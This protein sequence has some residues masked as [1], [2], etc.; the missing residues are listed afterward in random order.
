MAS[1][2]VVRVEASDKMLEGFSAG[3]GGKAWS[4]AT[5]E[6][7]QPHTSPTP[8]PLR[9]PSLGS[10]ADEGSTHQTFVT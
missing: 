7:R 4:T 5:A 1:D 9:C 8:C 10:L 2:P 6:E 3:K